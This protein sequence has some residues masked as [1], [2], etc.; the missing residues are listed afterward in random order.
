MPT[1]AVLVFGT[2]LVKLL[3][4][5]VGVAESV[6]VRLVIG[7]PSLIGMIDV[8]LVKMASQGVLLDATL[9]GADL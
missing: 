8:D 4:G 2:V 5:E 7:S 9:E 1:D 6:A 3:L